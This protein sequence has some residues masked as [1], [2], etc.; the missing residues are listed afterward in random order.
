MQATDIAGQVVAILAPVVSGG[1]SVAQGVATK[2]LGD[3]VSRRLSR[4]EEGRQAWNG[5]QANP[6][7]DSLV[8]YLLWQELERDISF[9][10]EV[11]EA[12]RGARRNAPAAVVQQA[13]SGTGSGNIQVGGSTGHIA[14]GGGSVRTSSVQKTTNK[15][16]SG[17]AT[18]GVVAI[19]VV[20]VVALIIFAG[21]KVVG[22]LLKSTKDGGLSASSTCEQ[23]LNT[24]EDDERQ[25]LA[26]IG[27]SEGFAGYSNPLALPEIQYECGAVPTMTL[28]ALIKRDGNMD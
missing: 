28:G 6:Q 17:G 13:M 10:S 27:I 26:D 3:L 20:V 5:F 21:V 18:A 25:A 24:D 2:V 8:R 7:N 22:G 11:E 9:R 12:L 23:F 19:V 15:K 4:N 14:T 1:A 16:K